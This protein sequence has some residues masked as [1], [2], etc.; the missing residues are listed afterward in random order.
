MY[1]CASWSVKKA[2]CWRI[3]TFELW[4][5]KRLLRIPWTARESN[6][7]ILKEINPEFSFEG[8]LL[9]LQCF[10]CL[11]QRA[12]S[13]PKTLMRGKDWRQKE[14]GWLRMRWWDSIID[15]VDMSLSKLLETVEDR[16][17]WW[18]T[19]EGVEKS[20]TWLSD[21]ITTRPTRVLLQC[22]NQEKL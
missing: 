3:D 9:K 22:G 2:E 19:I 1:G 21:W 14:K 15:S 16:G 20:W 4:S 7:S 18:A 10:G 5:W 11:M 6:Q 12:N 13:L 17:A 8:L